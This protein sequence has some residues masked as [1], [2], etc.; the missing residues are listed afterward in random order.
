MRTDGALANAGSM[1]FSG[2][3]VMRMRKFD[4]SSEAISEKG[5]QA[6]STGS[7]PAF[8]QGI[9]DDKNMIVGLQT[10]EW[11]QEKAFK[12]CWEVSGAQKRGIVCDVVP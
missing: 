9:N 11:P 5:V 7:V 10:I 4:G 12:E 3:D 1:P 6:S 8:I 2:L